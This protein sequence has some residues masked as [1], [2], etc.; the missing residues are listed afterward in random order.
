MKNVLVT[1]GA[2]FIGS[3]FNSVS[4]GAREGCTGHQPGCPYL[5]AG[6]LLDLEDILIWIGI[7]LSGVISAIGAWLM[8]FC[9][10]IQ[11]TQLSTLQP[12]PTWTDHS[13]S[14]DNSFKPT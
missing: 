4:T 10:N 13:W 6:S 12:K 2:G 1:G 8:I 11:S 9:I 7:S 14:R 3:N 5:Y